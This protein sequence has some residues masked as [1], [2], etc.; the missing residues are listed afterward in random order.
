V[1]SRIYTSYDG[2]VDSVDRESEAAVNSV[3][4][5]A[6]E[7]GAESEGIAA[8]DPG[9]QHLT[10]EQIE[11]ITH[12]LRAGRRLPPHLFPNLFETSREYE[13]AY[14]GKARRADILAE[15]MAIPLQPVRTFGT[16]RDDWSN[17]LILGDNLQVLRQLLRLKDDGYLRNA[18]GTDGVRLCY[19][20]PPFASQREFTGSRNEKA[21]IDRVAGAEFV[22]H[23]RRRL[24]LIRELLAD[25]GSIYVHLDL[26]KGHY[27]KV[28]LDEIFGEQNFRSEISRVKCNP[29]N[30]DQA[31]FGNVHDLIFFYSK[32]RRSPDT[33]TWNGGRE[34]LA[35]VANTGANLKHTPDGR[36]YT[37][38]ALHAKGVRSGQTGRPWRGVAPPPGRHWAYV[39][40][41]LDRLDAEGVVEW[42]STGNPRLIQWRDEPRGKKLQDIWEDFKD[43]GDRLARY[44]TEKNLDLLVTIVETSSREGDL[45]LDAFVGSGT[46][47]EAATRLNR[48]WIGIDS[49]KFA[50]YVSQSRLLQQAGKKAPDQSF[51]LYNAGLYDYR[52]LRDL[53]W[54]KY[55]EFV[56]QLFQC[57]REEVSIGGV[58]FQGYLGDHPVLVY[59]FKEQPSATI[60]RAFIDDIASLCRGRLGPRCFIIAPALAVEPYEDYIDHEGT[61]FFFLRIPYSVIAELHKRAF[62]EL[63]QPTSAATTNAPID[64]VG[65]DF[66]QPPRVEAQYSTQGVNFVVAIREFESEAFAAVESVENIENLAMVL[67]DYSYDGEVFDLDAVHFAED[68]AQQE[69]KVVIPRVRVAKTLMLIY[70][71]IYGNEHRE[72]KTHSDF[73]KRD[74][75]HGT[76]RAAKARPISKASKKAVPRT[77]R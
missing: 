5:D 23:L 73:G 50:I 51:T 1:A 11:E 65:F 39:H 14:R 12:L 2:P 57:R 55:L 17:M 75:R 10:E 38:G 74:V 34:Q 60:G 59:N 76:T 37:T 29:K 27:I 72:V 70:I 25:D 13:L 18:D 35:K 28:I 42:S 40:E 7:Y 8:E 45:V 9:P 20:D 48:R 32:S 62:S 77:N 47:L 56:L 64:S 31:A 22:E 15:T 16:A 3:N 63:R 30:F 24:I 36:P 4:P 49:G 68:L 21:Y 61:R 6:D 44:P 58:V 69:W 46:T 67:V 66:V 43:P 71:D 41:E 26:K 19:I 52:S 53:A 33:V 54:P